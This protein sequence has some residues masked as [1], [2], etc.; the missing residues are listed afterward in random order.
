MYNLF[1]AFFQIYPMKSLTRGS[2]PRNLVKLKG[3]GYPPTFA[4]RDKQKQKAKGKGKEK[5]INCN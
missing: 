3:K 4:I 2:V 5:K 1:S